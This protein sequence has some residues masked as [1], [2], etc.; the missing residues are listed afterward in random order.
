[1]NPN[2]ITSEVTHGNFHLERVLRS[3]AVNSGGGLGEAALTGNT[4]ICVRT[5]NENY[6]DF[7]KRYQAQYNNGNYRIQTSLTTALTLMKAYDTLILSPG[8]WSG[9]N[10]TP[11]NAVAPFCRMF[12]MN[13]AWMA[14]SSASTPALDVLARGW[15]IAGIEFDASTTAC[16]LRLRKDAT[17]AINRGADFFNVHDNLFY[18]GQGG[19][20]INGG[21]TYWKIH[22][23]HFSL[24]TTSGKGGVYVSSST[25]QVP[26]LGLIKENRFDNGIN[27]IYGGVT[28]GFNDTLI[29]ANNFQADGNGQNATILCD[30]RG[31]GGGNQVNGNYLDMA[32]A[33][34]ADT[35]VALVRANATDYGAGNMFK[36]GPQSEALSA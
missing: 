7:E 21:G 11:L 12:G 5:D 3:L 31:S 8:N 2:D 34:F 33:D 32:H 25:F 24:H 10:V 1:M 36:D 30:I 13:G 28:R 9:D 18:G 27:H 4:Y 29:E 16:G 35:G 17:G 19:L 6:A 23:N 26:A 15:E 14:P 20:D 22:N